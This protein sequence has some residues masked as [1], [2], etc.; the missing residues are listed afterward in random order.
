MTNRREFIVQLSLGTGVLAAGQ[1]MAQ[2]AALSETDPA[3]AAQGYKADA[4][5]VD[6]KKYPKYAAGQTCANC[7]L[8]QGKAGA[9]SGPCWANVGSVTLVPGA[10][11]TLPAGTVGSTGSGAGVGVVDA[12]GID[13]LDAGIG[14]AGTST[15]TQ[16]PRTPN[17]Y[18]VE[19]QGEAAVNPKEKSGLSVLYAY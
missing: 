12:S 15:S 14:V 18:T 10:H 11:N 13:Y 8:Y 2:G 1:A 3:A 17:I 16:T 9:A 4:T 5:K 6:V 7:A 19:V